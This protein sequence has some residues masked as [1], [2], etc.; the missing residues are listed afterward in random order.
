[1]RNCTG[2]RP[3]SWWPI[4]VSILAIG[5]SV[6]ASG[7]TLT[8]T[9]PAAP[10]GGWDQTARAM[11]R[12][13]AEI[14]P[15]ANVQV[16]NVP[17][18]AGTIG[19]ARFIQSERGNP[20]ALMVTGLV[21]VSGVITNQSP[22]S[23]GDT[24]PIARLTGEY[25][26]IAV[27]ASSPYQSLGDL[28]AA[29]RSNPGSISWG[30]GSAGGTDDLLVRLM[31]EQVG[32]PAS[33]VNYI[34]F[35]GGGAALAAVLGGQLSAAVSGYAEFAGQIAAG[36]LRVLAVSAPARVSGIDAPT[37]RESGIA[38]DLAN[39]RA[40]VAPPGVSAVEQ[41][42]LI[43]RVTR[44][45]TSAQWRS[46]L[47]KNGW[48][49]LFLAGPPFRQFLLAE[50]SRIDAVLRRLSATD[51]AAP[52]TMSVTLTPSTLPALIGMIFIGALTL[53]GVHLVRHRPVF[54][55]SGL[56]MVTALIVAL[57]LLPVIF[58]TLGF[59]AAS[60]LLFAT[61]AV[62]L[63]GARP[64]PRSIVVDLAVGAAF[65]IVLFLMFTR[66]LSVSLPGPALF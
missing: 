28:I 38:L 33:R 58:I 46:M 4:L 8:I 6:P 25:E 22:V 55:A 3:I 20:S 41:E 29:F 66:G 17:G 51:A 44:V 62:A 27:P 15:G 56:R 34:A 59:I 16:E 5:V 52:S 42:A 21:M 23:L 49:D 13:L 57:L 2:T 11:Q 24:T 48:D 37:L 54:D 7:Q 39:W 10:G 18:A 64:S 43:A 26:V 19:L 40:I 36:Q 14:E 53:S 50:Q 12:V 63:R 45:A 31:A 35:A 65:S 61:V 1:M 60:T 47:E 9:A 30:G 32:L